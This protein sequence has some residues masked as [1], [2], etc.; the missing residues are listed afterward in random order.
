M[1]AVNSCDRPDVVVGGD[2]RVPRPD[3]VLI[4]GRWQASTGPVVEIVS[5]VTDASVATVVAPSLEDA[6]AAVTAAAQAFAGEWP[7]WPL[8]RR[9]EVVAR[10]CDRMENTLAHIGAVWTVESGIPI[11]WANTLHRFA[12]RTAWRTALDSAESALA[13]HTRSTPVGEVLIEQRPVGPVLAVLPYNG[14]LA[15]IG[16]K[17]IPALLA[18]TAVVVKAAPESA[19][20]MRVVA[21]CAVEAGFPPGVLS[22]LVG[23]IEVSRR[24]V[25]NPAI[26]LIS[27]TGGPVAASDILIGTADRLP[28]TVFEL[29]GK[30]PAVLLEDVDLD[31]AMRS[32]V[33]G[34]MS[35]AGQVCAAL[36][37]IVVPA[38]RHDEI[39]E[40][41]THAY[42]GLHIGDPRDPATD[43]GPLANRAAYERTTGFVETAVREGATIA[44]GGR[45]PPGF[46]TGWFYEP[47]L[48]VNVGEQDTVVQQEVFGPVTV[49]QRYDDVDDAVRIANSTDY[50]LAASVY[51]ADRTGALAVAQRIRAGSVALNTFGPT[52]AAPFGGVKRSG[53]GRECGPE[54]I[55]EFTETTQILLG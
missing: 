49:V 14:P 54:G 38:A 4:G 10:F 30:S 9:H 22:I 7:Q 29:G 3:S 51:S 52:M 11:R 53:W 19:L 33:A 37:R 42:R 48:L 6:D 24:L 55:R 46:D 21:Q 35:G 2:L 23:D 13:P 26:E 25:R 50:G 40:A 28:R 31:R 44:C 47:T 43:H 8:T 15:T 36:S 16:S 39:V 27:F 20:M 17:V 12:A 1:S 41:L 45:R 18:G 32:L 34:A 5:P